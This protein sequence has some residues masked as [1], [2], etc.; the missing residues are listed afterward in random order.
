MG[1]PRSGPDP[2]GTVPSP[3][4]PGPQHT[5]PPCSSGLR[6]GPGAGSPRS[7]HKVGRAELTPGAVPGTNLRLHPG[8][9]NPIP[10]SSPFSPSSSR[11]SPA[12]P[13]PLALPR[14]L[15]ISPP[16]LL[17]LPSDAAHTCRFPPTASAPLREPRS[18]SHLSSACLWLR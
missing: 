8:E 5:P 11:T 4:S 1:R 12:I 14:P 13:F 6:G 3:R 2:E 16:P 10:F 17:N 9:T 15:P 18:L 7:W